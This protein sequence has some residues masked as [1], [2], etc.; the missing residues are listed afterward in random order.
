MNESP[1]PSTA[2]IQSLAWKEKEK[3]GEKRKGKISNMP[4]GYM[5][6]CRLRP[7]TRYWSR[8]RS[9]H[10]AAQDGR[11]GTAISIF[12]ALLRPA[13]RASQADGRQDRTTAYCD[14]G[15]EH[16]G[17]LIIRLNRVRSGL[18]PPSLATTLPGRRTAARSRPPTV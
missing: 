14:K 5:P 17:R 16:Q 2:M 10:G 15:R 13:Q 7:S 4:K 12:E 6:F 11:V 3:E 1:R 8:C 18:P 9:C